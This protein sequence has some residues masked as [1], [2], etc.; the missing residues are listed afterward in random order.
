MNPLAV[1]FGLI[2]ASDM[3]LLSDDPDPKAP[4]RILAGNRRGRPANKA[5]E[6]CTS[7]YAITEVQGAHC[8]DRD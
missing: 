5:G 6:S 3:L 2:R 7:P 4:E 1:H 8:P